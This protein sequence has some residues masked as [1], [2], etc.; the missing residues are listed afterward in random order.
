MS[1]TEF[2]TLKRSAMDDEE[3]PY[4]RP[5]DISSIKR[6]DFDRIIRRKSATIRA[7]DLVRLNET[8][9]EEEFFGQD[10]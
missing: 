7:Q 10:M 9:F 4:M 3:M 2:E 5:A 8:E 1:Q 6:F